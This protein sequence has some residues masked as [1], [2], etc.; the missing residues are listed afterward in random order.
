[1]E[2]FENIQSEY[3]RR[4]DRVYLSG[5]NGLVE[6]DF[7]K[8]EAFFYEPCARM[9]NE[10]V[11]RVYDEM[12][13]LNVSWP[14]KMFD[15]MKRVSICCQVQRRNEPVPASLELMSG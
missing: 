14:L 13:R 9:I 2:E 1:M 11:R 6:F 15:D 3:E 12:N 7:D 5:V 4:F 10:A 8:N